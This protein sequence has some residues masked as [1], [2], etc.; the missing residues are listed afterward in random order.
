MLTIQTRA[1]QN[2]EI[3]IF[4]RHLYS[5]NPHIQFTIERASVS[6]SKQ[7]NKKKDTFLYWHW[8]HGTTWWSSVGI[9]AYYIDK[10]YKGK[11]L[12]AS[13]GY[14]ASPRTLSAIEPWPTDC[15][16]VKDG[17]AELTPIRQN[18]FSYLCRGTERERNSNAEKS[19][20]RNKFSFVAIWSNTQK[21][22]RAEWL[23]RIFERGA[24]NDHAHAFTIIDMQERHGH[25]FPRSC[26]P[27]RWLLKTNSE[28]TK[29]V[30]PPTRWSVLLTSWK[31]ENPIVS[32][33]WSDGLMRT[34]SER[35]PSIL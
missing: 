33:G 5:I 16:K 8:K 4:Y 13:R 24:S 10:Y 21:A 19:D 26:M 14:K 22:E 17:P 1:T 32:D 35:L 6:S 23:L 30:I 18:V 29:I 7:E 15:N 2:Q 31:R 9:S 25:E 12:Q 34:I 28:A 27:S 3:N 11:H 20:A